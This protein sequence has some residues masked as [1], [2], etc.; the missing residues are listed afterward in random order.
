MTLVILIRSRC[1]YGQNP[2]SRNHPNTGETGEGPAGTCT[3]HVYHKIKQT[4][5][6]NTTLNPNC[7]FFPLFFLYLFILTI[8]LS[9][10]IFEF[11]NVFI[12]S[13]NR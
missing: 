9:Y 4:I 12:S 5:L 7:I 6:R 8:H 13:F 2:N 10:L 11:F 1:V 3:E